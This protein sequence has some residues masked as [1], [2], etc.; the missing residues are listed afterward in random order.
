MPEAATNDRDPNRPRGCTCFRLRRTARQVTRIYDSHLAPAGLTLTQYSLIST[1]ALGANPT[2]SV[3]ELAG[4]LN[5][6]RT[7]LTRTL[8]PLLAARLVTLAKGADKRSKAVTLT[9][10]G[11]T[12]FDTAKPLWRRAQNEMIERLGAPRVAE[13]H[14]L[15]DDS[16]A[17]LEAA[18]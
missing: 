3:H 1:L 6:D 8:K 14:H 17:T 10:A 13:L 16:F 9:P 18:G 7:T 4:V 12:A 5:M 11:R 2:P 15:L